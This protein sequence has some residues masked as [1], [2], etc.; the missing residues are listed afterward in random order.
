MSHTNSHRI[1]RYEPE[2]SLQ[3]KVSLDVD[4]KLDS[5]R[6]Q[7]LKIWPPKRCK[8]SCC[9]TK[10]KHYRTIYIVG[11]NQTEKKITQGNSRYIQ[12]LTMRLP[13]MKG[14]ARTK[15]MRRSAPTLA[16]SVG[17]VTSRATASSASKL[18]LKYW[19]NILYFCY[20]DSGLPYLRINEVIT[21]FRTPNTCTSRLLTDK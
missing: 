20:K 13:T 15:F 10:Y 3:G 7:L 6:L 17:T 5:Q 1:L 16:R 19:R 9:V 11:D 18:P 8:F 4:S 14:K 12:Y 21:C 2:N